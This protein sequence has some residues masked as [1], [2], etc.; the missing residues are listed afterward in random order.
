MG[1]VFGFVSKDLRLKMDT[2]YEFLNNQ[3]LSE[4]FETAK[5]MIEY[6]KAN[7]LLSKKGY[8]SGSRTLLRLHRGLDFIRVFLKSV[9]DLQDSD[10]TSAVCRA[11]YDQTLSNHHTFMVRSGAKLAMHTMPTREQLLKKVKIKCNCL[12]VYNLIHHGCF[13]ICGDNPEDIQNALD[14]LPKMLEIT[15]NVFDRIDNLY[16]VHDLHSLP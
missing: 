8:T 5:K 10:N 7:E 11:A 14:M 15:S 3:E 6:E 9:G 13:Q 1:V 2:L 4:N 16:T 12:K